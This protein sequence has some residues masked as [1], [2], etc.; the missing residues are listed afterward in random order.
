VA[1]FVRPFKLFLHVWFGRQAAA[2][3]SILGREASNSGNK[4]F[5]LQIDGVGQ[6][7]PQL[8]HLT[9]IFALAGIRHASSRGR[10][11]NCRP[12]E[13]MPAASRPRLDMKLY[14]LRENSLRTGPRRPFGYQIKMARCRAMRNLRPGFH[15]GSGRKLFHHIHFARLS[16]QLSKHRCARRREGPVQVSGQSAISPVAITANG[17]PPPPNRWQ[18]CFS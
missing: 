9:C 1:V 14:Q 8:V 10:A 4:K 7:P 12:S 5:Y 15:G 18:S 17:K 16:S 13:V 3:A 11:A 2:S 6:K